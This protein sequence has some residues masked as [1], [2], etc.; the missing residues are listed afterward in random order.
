[1][2]NP[3][4]TGTHLWVLLFLIASLVVVC[5]KSLGF[6][7]ERFGDFKDDRDSVFTLLQSEGTFG[8]LSSVSANR[9]QVD[10][11]LVKNL[12]VWPF[13]FNLTGTWKMLFFPFSFKIAE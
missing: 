3:R 6:L 1:M 2:I 8:P 5:W 9:E 12:R 4:R 10:R 7:L 11:W 13:L